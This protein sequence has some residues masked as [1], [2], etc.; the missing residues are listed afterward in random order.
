MDYLY[1]LGS[2][3]LGSRLKRLSD[4]L[5]QEVAKVY[6][7]QGLDFEPRWFPVFRFVAESGSAAITDIAFAVGITHP[8]VNQ[9]AQELINAEFVSAAA[10][11]KDKRRRMLSLSKKGKKLHAE[12]Q[13]VWKALHAALSDVIEE[14]E[15]NLLNSVSDFERALDRDSLLSRFERLSPALERGK[16]EMVEYTDELSMHFSRLNRAWIEKYFSLEQADWKLF[17]NPKKVIADGGDIFFARLGPKIIGTVAILKQDASTYQIAKMAV[18]EAYQGMGVGKKLLEIS[19]RRAADHGAQRI[20]LKTNRKLKAAVK[21]YQQ[22]GFVP[23]DADEPS[24]VSS[25]EYARVDLVMQLDL[26]LPSSV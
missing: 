25:S 14:T 24:G 18:D 22:L 4:R 13:T 20:T 15:S 21:L 5:G 7:A 19:I 10:D 11:P 26:S 17:M 16:V 8:A 23:V 6:E 3:A 1:E 12:I 9:I 2:L